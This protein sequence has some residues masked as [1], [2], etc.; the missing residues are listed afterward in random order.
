MV[1]KSETKD[2]VSGE[3]D[4]EYSDGGSANIRTHDA[5][6][7]QISLEIQWYL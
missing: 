1:Q 6:N 2:G 7:L 3:G 4:E 5:N